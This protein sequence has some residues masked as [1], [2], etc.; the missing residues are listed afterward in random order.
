[1][2]IPGTPYKKVMHRNYDPKKKMFIETVR[3]EPAAESTSV[4]DVDNE[5]L[6]NNL[7]ATGQYREYDQERAM[8]DAKVN[9]RAENPLEGYAIEKYMDSGYVAVNKKLK[10]YEYAGADGLWKK[11]KVNM[12]PWKTE[13]EAYNFI[14]EETDFGGR[15]ENPEDDINHTVSALAGKGKNKK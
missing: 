10:P 12:S 5:E 9:A 11:E 2:P 13:I 8:A 3:N 15:E 4:C 14:K 7:L 6:I 1:M